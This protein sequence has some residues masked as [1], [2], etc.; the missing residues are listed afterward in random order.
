MAGQVRRHLQVEYPACKIKRVRQ[1]AYNLKR[2]ARR[3]S[4]KRTMFQ[5]ALLKESP[6]HE[7]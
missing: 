6:H 3:N 7:A 2:F 5:L 4:R 1:M